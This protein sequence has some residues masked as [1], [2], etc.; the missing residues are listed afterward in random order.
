MDLK[1]FFK[2][3]TNVAVAFSGG[4]DSSYLLCEAKKYAGKVIAF[5]VKTSFQPDFETEDAK[6]MA[7]LLG[8]D[9]KFIKADIL[10]VDEVRKN[11][12]DRCYYCKKEIFSKILKAAKEE[13]IECVLDGTNAS[14][15]EDDRPGMRA[16][17]ELG[18]RS[19][20]RECGLTKDFIRKKS[21]E[22][23]LFTWDKPAYACLATREK[24]GTLITE[25]K[26]RRTE[27]AEG[28]LTGLGLYDLRVR[29]DEGKATVQ[30]R[31]EQMSVLNEKW[32][33]ISKDLGQYYDE[34]SIDPEGR[35]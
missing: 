17:K 1:E 22:E 20:L 11:G 26:L 7:S 31:K 12:K 34:V 15:S 14:D 3:N 6:K 2:E 33:I 32:D 9:L 4:V 35:K 16:L 21:K 28:Y 23:G 13:G 29:D 10:N 27:K 25:E 18:V 24:T 5:Y 30:V 8:A 19:P